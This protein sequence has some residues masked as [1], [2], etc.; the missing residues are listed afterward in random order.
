MCTHT[1]GP[2]P[3]SL[4]CLTL[5]KAP[6]PLDYSAKQLPLQKLLLAFDPLCPYL[7]NHCPVNLFSLSCLFCSVLPASQLPSF[8]PAHPYPAASVAL[9]TT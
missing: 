5:A 6:S 9:L 2:L 7:L 8:I 3:G 1:S 4:P